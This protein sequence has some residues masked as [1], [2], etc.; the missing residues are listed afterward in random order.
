[1]IAATATAGG[2]G[3]EHTAGSENDG[4]IAN[5]II[6]AAQPYGLYIGIARA[7]PDK[8]EHVGDIGGDGKKPDR[9]HYK[10]CLTL[11]NQKNIAR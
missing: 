7:E 10:A 9:P 11:E 2:T 4:S 1:M 6:A 3:C 8:N 5:R